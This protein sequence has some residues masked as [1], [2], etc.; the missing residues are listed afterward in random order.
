MLIGGTVINPAMLTNSVSRRALVSPIQIRGGVRHGPRV[1]RAV[2]PDLERAIY[3]RTALFEGLAKIGERRC[4]DAHGRT[5]TFICPRRLATPV[6]SEGFLK[7]GGLRST[8]S[9]KSP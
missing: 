3:K 9:E 8:T 5:G 6:A 4:L 1:S 7:E 2:V